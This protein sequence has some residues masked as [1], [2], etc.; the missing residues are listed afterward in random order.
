MVMW[1][2]GHLLSLTASAASNNPQ[3]P[4][5]ARKEGGFME[6]ALVVHLEQSNNAS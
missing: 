3:P 2:S 1:L 5:R 4:L 6:R